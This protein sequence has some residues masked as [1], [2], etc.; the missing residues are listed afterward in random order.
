M[1]DLRRNSV[2][3]PFRVFGILT[4]RACDSPIVCTLRDRSRLDWQPKNCHHHLV[5]AA[6]MGKPTIFDTEL[7]PVWMEIDK[8]GSGRRWKKKHNNRTMKSIKSSKH[9][10]S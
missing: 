5:A 6:R 8:N 4:R 9:N 10:N 2:A 1:N 3:A 7:E